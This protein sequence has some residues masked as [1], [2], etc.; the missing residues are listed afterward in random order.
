[1]AGQDFL[2]LSDPSPI[3]F[4]FD[5]IKMRQ[6]IGELYLAS[7][8]FNVLCA[9]ADFD[10][11]RVLQEKRDIEQYLGIQRPLNPK[12]VKEIG[13]FVNFSDASFPGSIIIAV[14]ER[15]V[16]FSEEASKMTLSNV[17]DK[18]DPLLA[19]RIARVID[20]QHRIAG[21]Y[22]YQYEEFDC[23]VTILVGADIA[24]QAQMFSRVNLNQTKVNASLAYDLYELSLSR[25]PQKTCHM[26]A[27][28]LD[29]DNGGPFFK[30][31]KRL[32]VATPGRDSETLTQATV[33]RGIMGLISNNPDADRDALL[34]GRSLRFGPRDN[35]ERLIFR[36]WFIDEN[37]EAIYTAVDVFFR[38]V[39]VR[40]E[41]AWD[42]MDKGM[43]LARTNGFMA[44]MRFLRD[45]HLRVSGPSEP[46]SYERHLEIL[47][48]IK[49]ESKDFNTD[50]FDPGTSGQAKLYRELMAQA[51]ETEGLF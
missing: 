36:Q 20:G 41:E 22:D 42:S 48:R 47:N 24:D 30:R 4:T 13:D 23:P 40:W 3:S 49:M 12:R 10:V 38:A 1:M 44:L 19:R 45:I 2:N 14:D 28:A 31:I 32:G 25:S 50:A 17:L 7:I 26:I 21:L 29:R 15:A 9:I 5:C 11:R 18:D 34:R 51:F 8:P 37:D 27:V 33:V 43:M 35:E 46:V 16:E 39:R 6:P